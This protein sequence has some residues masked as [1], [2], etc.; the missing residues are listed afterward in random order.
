M[1]LGCPGTTERRVFLWGTGTDNADFAE[2]IAIAPP[3]TVEN[4]VNISVGGGGTGT[5]VIKDGENAALAAEF[6]AW[7]KLGTEG[8]ISTWELLGFDPLNTEVW[9]DQEITHNPENKFVK[10]FQNNPF[11]PLLEIQDSIGHLE[12]FTNGSMPSVNNLLNTQTLND[13]FEN[14]VP[15]EDALNQAQSDL[16][17]E[18]GE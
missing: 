13:I 3:P 11:E 6:I 14:D 8:N 12:S 5:A 15:I 2:K 10:Y 17:N 7:A 1:G 18:L 4:P 9:A 16:Q